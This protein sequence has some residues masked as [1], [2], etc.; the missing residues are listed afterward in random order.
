MLRLGLLVGWAVG[1]GGVGGLG[2]GLGGEGGLG[3]GLGGGEGE[4]RKVFEMGGMG[5]GFEM[6]GEGSGAS[7]SGL[8]Q[9]D[10]TGA[11]VDADTNAME[12]PKKRRKSD[13]KGK[14]KVKRRGTNPPPSLSV[15]VSP[16]SPPYDNNATTTSS[17]EVEVDSP[18]DGRQE[19][20]HTPMSVSPRPRPVIPL[21]AIP[22]SKT[23]V[24]TG[25]I[26]PV[27]RCCFV[28]ECLSNCDRV[29]LPAPFALSFIR[30]LVQLRS[31]SIIHAIR[32]DPNDSIR[33]RPTP[34]PYQHSSPKPRSSHQTHSTAPSSPTSALDTPP[35]RTPTS[36]GR[37][38]EKKMSYSG[39][40]RVGGRCCWGGMIRR[41]RK[42]AY[43]FF[44]FGFGLKEV[45][46]MLIVGWLG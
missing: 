46:G 18:T 39:S 30:S 42:R 23:G 17:P 38:K 27:S 12:R 45:C 44:G 1:R 21:D 20:G 3:G 2:G 24:R 16:L 4:E 6:V 43:L 41:R 32:F 29:L 34:S 26:S 35:P 19:D 31:T 40:E 8:K 9:E 37:E 15:S 25:M 14:P 33:F 13:A 11:H 22:L 10:G 5:E 7:G 28:Y 36:P